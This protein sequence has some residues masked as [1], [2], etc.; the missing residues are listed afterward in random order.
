MHKS[1][2][3][4]DWYT[5]FNKLKIKSAEYKLTSQLFAADSYK[6]SFKKQMDCYDSHMKGIHF[7]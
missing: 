3:I 4:L 6:K 7:S 2:V 5:K 1:N